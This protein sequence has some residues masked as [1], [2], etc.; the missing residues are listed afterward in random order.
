[1]LIESPY[2]LCVIKTVSLYF[3]ICF[4]LQSL[5]LAHDKY[6]LFIAKK[7]CERVRY[8]IRV[9]NQMMRANTAALLMGLYACPGSAVH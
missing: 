7:R 9:Y 2:G 4:W 1:M 3:G 5:D 8:T 6:Y